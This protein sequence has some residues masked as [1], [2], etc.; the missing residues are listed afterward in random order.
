MSSRYVRRRSTPP[1]HHAN[2]STGESWRPS[3]GSRKPRSAAKPSSRS[4]VPTLLTTSIPTPLAGD[5]HA[6]IPLVAQPAAV[7]RAAQLDL[8]EAPGEQDLGARRP[9]LGVREQRVDQ[10]AE[11]A[12]ID[13]GVVVDQRHEVDVVER[14]DAHVA[15]G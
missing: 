12:P 11:P 4:S 10:R 6:E 2:T 3:S 9:E 15:P 8:E 7:R 5:E 1:P 13:G 14:A